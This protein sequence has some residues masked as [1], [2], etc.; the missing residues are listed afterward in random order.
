MAA[1]MVGTL[2]AEAQLVAA[3]LGF[4]ILSGVIAGLV[5][6]AVLRNRYLVARGYEHMFTLA[7][8]VLLFE[9]CGAFVAESGLMAVTV[10]GVVVAFCL[11]TITVRLRRLEVVG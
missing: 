1:P 4:G 8:V 9:A 6:A 10:A 2:A 5:L 11:V 3:S 7:G